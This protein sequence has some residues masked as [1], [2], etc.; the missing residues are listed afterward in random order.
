MQLHCLK[1]RFLFSTL[2]TFQQGLSDLLSMFFVEIMEFPQIV[3][4]VFHCF[5][6][7]HDPMKAAKIVLHSFHVFHLFHEFVAYTF[8]WFIIS[9]LSVELNHS[10]HFSESVET[11]ESVSGIFSTKFP[12]KSADFSCFSCKGRFSLGCM[13]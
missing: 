7:F 2:Y 3:I 5:H 13:L 4:C 10:P 6:V 12:W 8:N 9:I 1:C 11:L